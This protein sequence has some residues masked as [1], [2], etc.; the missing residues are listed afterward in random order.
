MQKTAGITLFS[1]VF[2]LL[3]LSACDSLAPPTLVPTAALPKGVD[4]GALRLPTIS[5]SAVATVEPS[6]TPSPTPTPTPTA[7]PTPFPSALLSA[8]LYCVEI[9][10]YK[11]AVQ[12]FERLAAAPR[13]TAGQLQAALL[14]LGEAHLRLGGFADAE[15]TLG[16]FL[17]LY[18]TSPEAAKANFWLG[19]ARQG[20]EDWQ[21][22]IAAYEEYLEYDDTLSAY[23]GDL[24]A[25]CHLEMGDNAA[26]V[27][28]YEAALAGTTAADRLTSIREHLARAYLASDQHEA[29]VE[30]YD[31]VRAV[32]DDSATLARMDYLAGYALI[33]SGR[34]E[35][36][37]ARYL[38]AVNNYPAAY[39]SYLA[40]V[41]LVDA[42][43]RVDDFQRGL[44]DY[45]ADA[46]LPAI[47]AFYRHI[48]ADP[49][50]HPADGHWYVARSYVALGN[51]PSALAELDLLIDTH[52]GDPLWDD[53]WLEKAK[54]QAA[55]GN[56]EAAV[57]T[58]LGFAS[59]YPS[60]QLAPIALWRAAALREREDDWQ[61]AIQLYHRLASDYPDHE[62]APEALLRAGLMAFHAGDEEEAILDWEELVERYPGSEWIAP[63]LLWLGITLPPEAAAKYGAQTA[64]LAPDS[65]YAIRAADLVAGVAPFAPPAAI[66]WPDGEADGKGEAEDWLR[67]WLELDP[68]VDLATAS[69]AISTDPRWERGLRLWDLGLESEARAELNGVRRDLAHD[70]LGSYQM[71][72]AFR[73]LGLYRS[74][75][76]AANALISASPAA[77]PLDVPR[78]VGQ[79]AY[80]AYYRQLV[81]SVADEYELDPLFIFAMIRQESLF[82]S[83]A[84]SWASARGLMQ[85]IPSTGEY[86]AGQL[87][88]SGFQTEDLYKPFV[89]IRFG[90]FYVAEQL[91]AFDG[92]PYVALSAYNG[93]PGNAAYWSGLAPDSPDLFLEAITFSEPRRYIQRIYTHY[94]YYRALYDTQA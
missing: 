42:G 92:D 41:E 52:P 54:I 93:G 15:A 2:A 64:A 14:G 4:P 9:G 60:Y 88:W 21:G 29:A 6:L 17:A 63:A 77:S 90:A 25:E 80:P 18:P 65:Y 30:Q 51:L 78:F 11:A 10:D 7:T 40:L 1:L 19:Q 62:D 44:V 91:E 27:E 12:N 67:Q 58:C 59:G 76:L 13:S 53:A 55:A 39:D 23:V 87:G 31:A 46:Y 35:E 68:G 45:Y 33:V 74:S 84:R 26:A 24:I 5:S 72:L 22:A 94:A 69:S 43:I 28:A 47:A 3:G 56:A 8:A 57:Q 70:P 85:V 81:E 71:A 37:Y 49:E 38:R 61:S 34:R 79:L 83:S 48:E 32:T 16:E 36:G 75:I 89:S 86:I 82:E 73:E 50:N 66:V 20:Q